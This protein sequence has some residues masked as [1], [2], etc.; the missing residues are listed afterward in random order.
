MNFSV[1]FH[2]STCSNSWVCESCCHGRRYKP[3]I[4]KLFFFNTGAK[5]Y[6][7]TVERLFDEDEYEAN[8]QDD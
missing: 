2:C 5:F 4:I 1:E 8:T 7:R 6:N 3:S